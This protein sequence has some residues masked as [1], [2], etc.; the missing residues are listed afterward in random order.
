MGC[1]TLLRL[2]LMGTL[3]V[4][5]G[6]KKE[7]HQSASPPKHAR[8]KAATPLHKAAEEGDIEQVRSLVASGAGVNAQTTGDWTPLHYAVREGHGEIV[9]LLLHHGANVN[10]RDTGGD[11]PLDVAIWS[12][13]P[14]L[15]E[16]LIAEGAEVKTENNLGE[17]PLHEAADEGYDDI[18]KLLIARG[19][20]V[21][22]ANAWNGSPLNCAVSSGHLQTVRLLVEAGADINAKCIDHKTPLHYAAESGH[23]DVA[24]FLIAEGALL[25]ERNDAGDTPLHVAASRGWE[26]VA[27]L[28]VTQ[29]AAIESVTFDERTA[30]HLA[31]KEG[32]SDVVR[33]LVAHGA[34]VQ[35]R[36]GTGSAPLHLAAASG[37]GE[38]IEYL[39]AGD[40]DVN[41]RA[42]NG[43]TPLYA[44][45]LRGH[46]EGTYLLLSHGADPNL[47][48]SS[49]STPLHCAARKGLVQLAEL[50]LA[51]GADVD[52]TTNAGYTPL[53]SA[54]RAGHAD[55]AALLIAHGADATART[56]E[57]RTPIDLAPQM[58]REAFAAILTQ[59]HPNGAAETLSTASDSHAEMI[60]VRLPEPNT[61]LEFLVRD[62]TAFA[63]DLY[64]QLRMQEGNL[65]FSPYSVS[66]ALAMAFAAARENTERQM[67]RTLHFTLNQDSLHP[68]FAELRTMLENIQQAGDI[69][70]SQANSLWPQHRYPFL[71]AYLS[72]IERHYGVSITAVD[73]TSQAARQAACK[74][75]NA[76]VQEKTEGRISN[77]ISEAHLDKLTRLVLTNA[78]YFKGRWENEFEPERSKDALFFLSARK[79]VE[80]AMM[81][82][83][84][85][86]KYAETDSAQIVELP[87]RGGEVWMLVV[88]S[89]Q[90]EGLGALERSLSVARL[91]AWR[92]TLTE[93]RVNVMLPKFAMTFEAWLGKTLK[94][95]GMAE[96]LTWPGANFAGLDGDPNWF[97]IDEV[98][99]KAYVDVDERG[100]EAAAAT[101]VV[102]MLGGMPAPPP[103]FRA[104]HPF[105]FLIQENRT[106]SILF[107]GRVTDPTSSGQ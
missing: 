58:S 74:T 36:D 48:I 42:S 52:A 14:D 98:I 49:G 69:K 44:A 68:A 7:P 96:A 30:L 39:I 2:I 45:V 15:A 41:A 24:A 60:E 53:H 9:A 62:N 91:N 25:E 84:E 12:E 107:I 19:A 26:E 31:A 47:A 105:L 27:E 63:L 10:A 95:M 33:V 3:A 85:H 13:H 67:A 66:T 18:V 73:Y 100:T 72:L 51:H 1:K 32:H 89:R 75:I 61:P 90:I 4:A 104:D 46:G 82:Q 6:C 70:L 76:W 35:A 71:P 50:L 57:G 29:G 23:A 99:H 65:F 94:A 54:V 92:N 17:T 28:L 102:M 86:F 79:C 93:R 38:T 21:N 101:A 87:Y 56:G 88:L 11:T 83:T 55:V 22:A 80:V 20:N 37:E 103:V 59:N 40:A 77:L 43:R 64:R 106:G 97:Y 81:D 5:G 78:I 16:R 8:S 34:N